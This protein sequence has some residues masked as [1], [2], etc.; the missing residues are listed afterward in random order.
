[1]TNTKLIEVIILGVTYGIA[2]ISMGAYAVM[3]IIDDIQNS[4]N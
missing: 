4:R 2:V 3:C 1:M